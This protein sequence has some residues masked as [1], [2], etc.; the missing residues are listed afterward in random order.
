MDMSSMKMSG[1]GIV[2]NGVE[3]GDIVLV[4]NK[5]GGI[6]PALI[7]FITGRPWSHTAVGSLPLHALVEQKAYAQVFEANLLCMQTL[8]NDYLNDGMR[9]RVYRFRD[10]PMA[11]VE[12]VCKYQLDH[13]NG[14]VY[15][16]AQLLWFVYRRVIELLHLP[17]RWARYNFFPKHRICT[18]VVWEFLG[19]FRYGTPGTP[20][21]IFLAQA[22]NLRDQN[23][24]HPGDI[25][26]IMQSCV[27]LGYADVVYERG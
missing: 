15:G 11:W 21:S 18:E 22:L 19:A 23:S 12:R 10:V 8:W 17:T 7:R 20:R 24:V 5:E 26:D 4:N 27:R 9:V 2:F 1:T 6:L 13:Y 16:F 14:E 25:E 3:P